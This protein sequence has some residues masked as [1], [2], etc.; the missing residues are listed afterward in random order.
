MS[1]LQ[2]LLTSHL[3]MKI[4]ST[5]TELSTGGGQRRGKTASTGPSAPALE[6][7]TLCTQV[8]TTL[9]MDVDACRRAPPRAA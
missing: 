8:W 9:W 1:G 7:V 5:S 6:K 3:C 4:S 2:R